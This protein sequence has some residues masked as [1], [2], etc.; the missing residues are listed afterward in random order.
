M[1]EF[2]IS[3]SVSFCS[4]FNI[5]LVS[6]AAICDRRNVKSREIR[7]SQSA[8]TGNFETN[9]RFTLAALAL[10]GVSGSG[11]LLSLA[12]LSW[13]IASLSQNHQAVR[14]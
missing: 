9:S 3:W 8:A 12:K 4:D 13:G 14:A 6:E 7:R 1:S 10:C 5:R 2:R 11:L